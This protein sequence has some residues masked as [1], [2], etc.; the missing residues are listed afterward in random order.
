MCSFTD[1]S[2]E[3][4]AS[5]LSKDWS[6]GAELAQSF[7][8]FVCHLVSAKGCFV[9]ASL[10]VLVQHMLPF[11]TKGE[12]ATILDSVHEAIAQILCIFPASS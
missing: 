1:D 4:L 11:D 8:Q 2:D 3:L 9:E 12:T 6:A 7:T 5:V 10:R